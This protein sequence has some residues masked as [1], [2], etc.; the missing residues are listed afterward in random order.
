MPPLRSVSSCSPSAR[1]RTVTAHSLKAIG[2]FELV[3]ERDG[4]TAGP[5]R[6]SQATRPQQQESRLYGTVSKS[7]NVAANQRFIEENFVTGLTKT[8][9]Y[10]KFG[11]AKPQ[12]V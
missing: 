2:I 4:F 5:R 6:A 1:A 10:P 3:G 8:A 9:H 11:V 12:L 7:Q